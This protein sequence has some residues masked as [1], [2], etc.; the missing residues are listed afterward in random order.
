[1]SGVQFT[2]RL[3]EY[4]D[5]IV[6]L[7]ARNGVPPT[8]R[9]IGKAVGVTS[10]NAVQEMLVRLRALGKVEWTPGLSRS[11]RVIPDA[12]P[13][14]YG[15]ISPGSAAFGREALETLETCFGGRF[16]DRSNARYFLASLHQEYT[17]RKAPSDV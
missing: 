7:T 16:E 12:E 1:M 5:V 17:T 3:R 6:E 2:Q 13:I 4:L 10:T 9:E 8:R 15:D 11:V 14:D